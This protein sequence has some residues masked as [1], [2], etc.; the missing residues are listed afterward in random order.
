MTQPHGRV[1]GEAQSKM[2]ADLLRTPP[3][4]EQLGDHL[5]KLI[6]DFDAPSVR[7]CHAYGG[8]T[9]SVERPIPATGDRVAPQ[10]PRDGRRRAFEPGCDRPDAQSGL[11]EIGDLDA[12]VL[13]EIPG[14]APADRET[15]TSRAATRTLHP[16]ARSSMSRCRSA[17]CGRRP[18][19]FSTRRDDSNTTS[20]KSREVLRLHLETTPSKRGEIPAVV[21]ERRRPAGG[22]SLGLRITLES[23]LRIRGAP[24]GCGR[25]RAVFVDRQPDGY[26]TAPLIPAAAHSLTR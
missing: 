25:V 4:P 5:A 14:A 9:M 24:G 3:L 10:F 15:P 13:G 21:D 20:R 1:V 6:V 2:A 26:L 23:A 7:A 12:L 17:G 8:A 16:R 19:P 18:G 22:A 11:T